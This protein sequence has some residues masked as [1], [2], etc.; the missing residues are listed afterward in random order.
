[1]LDHVHDRALLA[2]EA[3]LE[4]EHA[5]GDGRDDAEVVGDEEEREAEIGAQLGEQLEHGR[6]NGDVERGGDLVA[7]EENGIGRER[8]RDRDSLALAARQLAGVAL[9][10]AGGE[11]D[12]LEQA[13]AF[14]RSRRIRAGRAIASPTRWRGLSESYGF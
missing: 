2:D 7:D 11:P 6:L 4:H 10:E 3:A 9:A 5:V 13:A 12:T 14:D 8:A 1:M